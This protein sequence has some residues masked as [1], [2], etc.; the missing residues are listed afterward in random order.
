MLV[1]TPATATACPVAPLPPPPTKLT[2]GVTYPDPPCNTLAAVTA[3]AATDA[4]AP[5][6]YPPSVMVMVGTD[7]YPLPWFVIV[8]D[9]M[10][11]GAAPVKAA[12]AVAPVP[13]PPLMVTTG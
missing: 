1:I 13:P 7:E 11:L 9:A 2:V 8:I 10:V 5:A 6:P 4:L 12:V 3:P